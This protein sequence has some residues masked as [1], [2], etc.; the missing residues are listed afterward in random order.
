MMK[1][2]VLTIAVFV[3]GCLAGYAGMADMKIFGDTVKDV[4]MYLLYILMFPEFDFTNSC[5]YIG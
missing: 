3:L 2:T 4:P 5:L 1:G